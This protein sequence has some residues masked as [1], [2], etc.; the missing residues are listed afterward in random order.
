MNINKRSMRK[1]IIAANWKMNEDY[2]AGLTLFSEV[3]R[4]VPEEVTGDQE[5]LLLFICIPW[6][7]EQKIQK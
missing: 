5:V 6:R 2:S 7:N 3:S 4:L 1:K